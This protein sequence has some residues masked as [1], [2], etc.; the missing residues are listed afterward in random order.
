MPRLS[1]ILPIYGVEAYLPRAIDSIRAQSFADWEAILVDDGSP[2]RCGEICDRAA[3]LD[4][5]FRV[6]HQPNAGVAAARNAGLDAAQGEYVHFFDPD[7]F[8]EPAFA[9]E[10]LQ[11]SEGA[12]ILIFGFYTELQHRDGSTTRLSTSLPPIQGSFDFPA[13]QEAFPRLITSHYIWNR[14]YRRALLEENRCR[15]PDHTLGEDATFNYRACAQPFRRLV[16]LPSPYVHYSV[17]ENSA[18]GRFHP[19]R[20]K[21]NF[22]ISREAAALASRWKRI[23][24]PEYRDALAYCALR[25]L[26]LGVKNLGLSPLNR[27][28][29]RR[30]LR[31]IMSDARLREAVRIV[32]L[33][34]FGSTNDRVKLALLKLHMYDAVV[35]LASLH[36]KNRERSGSEG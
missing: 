33:K 28:E 18:V 23:D 9:Q 25:D 7:D 31:G 1:F 32:P 10:A 36:A 5:R 11:A 29:K 24:Q 20:L 35:L 13:F 6:I 30:W 8:L 19:E 2:D 17:R 15:F 22:Y 4:R 34:R 27:R 16:A 26:Q 3:A 21:D 14:L 12:D